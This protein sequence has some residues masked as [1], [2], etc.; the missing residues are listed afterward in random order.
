MFTLRKIRHHAPEFPMHGNLGVKGMAQ[1][2]SFT[3][4]DSDTGFIAGGFQTQD[5]HLPRPTPP[6][7]AGIPCNWF[8]SH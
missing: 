5:A 7:A 2:S 8:I 3:V 4:V 6:R 1:Q